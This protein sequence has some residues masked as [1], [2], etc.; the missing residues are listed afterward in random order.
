MFFLWLLDY[1][2]S[3]VVFITTHVYYLTELVFNKLVSWPVFMFQ[4]SV[5]C[6]LNSWLHLFKCCLST[7]LNTLGTVCFKPN[8]LIGQSR[9]STF[10]FQKEIMYRWLTLDLLTCK[11]S[12]LE[13]VQSSHYLQLQQGI[14]EFKVLQPVDLEICRTFCV[15]LH[16]VSIHGQSSSFK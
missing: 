2:S 13:L 12:F 4:Y 10:Q 5:I 3:S 9:K 6:L 11:C 8:L 7:S 14:N 1:Y 15:S 16:Q